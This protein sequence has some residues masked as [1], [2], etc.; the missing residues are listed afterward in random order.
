MAGS[1]WVKLVPSTAVSH[2]R[3][4]APPPGS[5]FAKWRWEEATDRYAPQAT[6]R[7]SRVA[8]YGDGRSLQQ[9]GR[10]VHRR[11]KQVWS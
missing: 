10:A 7:V 2:A 6:T 3:V 9:C 1:D 11:L 8:A 4:D 5:Q